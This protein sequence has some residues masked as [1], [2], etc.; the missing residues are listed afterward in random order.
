MGGFMSALGKI[1]KAG[2]K[3]L[4][5]G[6]TG[7]KLK[8][9]EDDEDDDEWGLNSA[10]KAAGVASYKKG[11]TVRKTGPAILH[12]GERVLTKAQARKKDPGRKR[13]SK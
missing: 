3:G 4:V 13:M 9:K 8:K 1:G 6:L 11:G 7:G 2:A 10:L 12:K 5:N